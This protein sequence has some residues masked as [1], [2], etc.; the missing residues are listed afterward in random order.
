MSVFK[1]TFLA[2]L[3]AVSLSKDRA[4]RVVKELI[5]QGEIRRQE[6]RKLLDDMMRRAEAT[7]R[8]VE[9]TIN[10]Q[11]DTAYRKINVATQEQ[12]RKMERRIH[13]LE[14]ELAKKSAGSGR[15]RSAAGKTS[16]RRRVRPKKRK[17]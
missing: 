9:E 7:R 17:Q 14:R 5:A 12:L 16:S 2:G 3:G 15:K 10:T 6:G 8:E 13:G 4:K 11:V 1:K